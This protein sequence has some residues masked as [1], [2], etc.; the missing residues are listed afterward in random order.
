MW[1]VLEEKSIPYQYIEVN[2]YHKPET[3]LRLNPKGLV[4][5][6]EFD[7]KPLY[8]ST[9]I[10]EFLE[11]QYPNHGLTLLPSDAFEKAKMR[12]WINYVTTEVVT[13]FH[14]FLQYQSGQA[15]DSLNDVRQEY[16]NT[17]KQLTQAMNKEGPFFLGK[18]PMLIDFVLGPWAIRHWV[19]DYYKSGLGIPAEGQGEADEETWR[20]WRRWMRAIE[21]R[22]SVKE[23]TSETEH[24][25]PIYRR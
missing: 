22:K 17:L 15:P 24:Y 20:R 9:I 25:L 10:C 2:P 21:N 8:E 23:T 4:P 6:L 14:R 12:I 19:F 5:T 1:T 11:D 18:E 13:G 16:L 3:L 7:G